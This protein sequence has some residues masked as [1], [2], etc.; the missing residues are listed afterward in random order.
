MFTVCG[1]ECIGNLRLCI[2]DTLL[3]KPKALKPSK[4]TVIKCNST[5]PTSGNSR[6]SKFEAVE[7][8]NWLYGIRGHVAPEIVFQFH[9]GNGDFSAF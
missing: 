5:V 8:Q 9:E 6:S 2:C 1:R 7:E 3:I 4:F